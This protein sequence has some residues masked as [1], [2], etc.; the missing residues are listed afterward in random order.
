MQAESLDVWWTF[1]AEHSRRDFS[2][3]SLVEQAGTGENDVTEL[4][5]QRSPNRSRLLLVPTTRLLWSERKFLTRG[6]VSRNGPRGYGETQ[7]YTSVTARRAIGRTLR[8]EE[9]SAHCTRG[10][11]GFTTFPVVVLELCDRC[12]DSVCVIMF[13]FAQGVH[14]PS[15]RM[16][17]YAASSPFA[18]TAPSRLDC[19]E[20]C[21][22]WWRLSTWKVRTEFCVGAQ[23]REDFD[24]GRHKR[25]EFLRQSLVLAC[26]FGV[27][28]S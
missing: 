24:A 10:V 13:D 3:A 25:L 26:P 15:L 4:S 12:F 1:F 27:S 19:A 20:G 11:G 17:H 23:R 2:R 22:H 8:G 5:R 14:T 18:A 9:D 16:A 21:L 6:S 28:E 7:K